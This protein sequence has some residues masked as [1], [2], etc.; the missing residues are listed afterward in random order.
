MGQVHALGQ[1]FLVNF[2]RPR[3]KIDRTRELAVLLHY[4]PPP[5]PLMI[6]V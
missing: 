6:R 2:I 4:P 3:R 1:G 5:R